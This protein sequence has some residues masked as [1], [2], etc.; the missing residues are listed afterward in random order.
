MPVLLRKECD[1]TNQAGTWFAEFGASFYGAALADN[2]SS[3][4]PTELMQ[5]G[6]C[7]ESAFIVYS[8]YECSVRHV[9]PE[10]LSNNLEALTELTVPVQMND[11]RIG[12]R[13]K[14]FK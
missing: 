5:S 9:V 13:R 3:F 11:V 12:S 1:R 6:Q 8:S 7:S 10:I 14:S 4:A 2:S